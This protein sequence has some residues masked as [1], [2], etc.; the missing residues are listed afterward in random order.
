MKT[1]DRESTVDMCVHVYVCMT[2]RLLREIRR[3]DM[4]GCRTSRTAIAVRNKR[5][6]Q[7]IHKSLTNVL[8]L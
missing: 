6:V 3:T 7:L 4:Q 8:L 2:Q 1:E 5:P